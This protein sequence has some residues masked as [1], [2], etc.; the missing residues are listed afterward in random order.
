MKN[1]RKN[2]FLGIIIA[3]ASITGYI[4]QEKDRQSYVLEMSSSA[5][6]TH[7]VADKTILPDSTTSAENAAA[8]E[9]SAS[10]KININTANADA[11]DT[12]PGIGPVKAQRIIEY[13]EKNGE[14]EVIEDIMNVDGI[15]RKTFENLMDYITV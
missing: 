15:G 6:E 14:F 1:F 5:E 10:D 2:L 9:A 4:L 8:G 13:R 11:L 12:L 7:S 3:A